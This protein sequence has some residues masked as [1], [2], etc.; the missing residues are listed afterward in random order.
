MCKEKKVVYMSCWDGCEDIET[1]GIV[2]VKTGE[3][4]CLS[5]V[6]VG[7]DYVT[8]LAEFVKYD[9][10]N[11]E[12]VIFDGYSGTIVSKIDTKH[13]VIT[14]HGINFIVSEELGKDD[15]HRICGIA[16]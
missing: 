13:H 6:E 15:I 16:Y 10:N 7:K 2:N 5:P 8:C 9:E 1:E 12:Q 3:V 14:I 11:I 4:I